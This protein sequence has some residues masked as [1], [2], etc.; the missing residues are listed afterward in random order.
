MKIGSLYKIISKVGLGANNNHNDMN[1]H[2]SYKSI[3]M[4]I[5]LKTNMVLKTELRD[6]N[7]VFLYKGKLF[8]RTV[9]FP[10]LEKWFEE[11]T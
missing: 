3:I 9:W 5:D 8:N 7:I 4:L 2:I 1:E 6:A 10:Y 11:V